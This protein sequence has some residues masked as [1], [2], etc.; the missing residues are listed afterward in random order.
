MQRQ[1][2]IPV[3]LGEAK[4]DPTPK[5]TDYINNPHDYFIKMETSHINFYVLGCAGNGGIPQHEV[6]AEMERIAK[7]SPNKPSFFILLG[8]N[9][10]DH[11]VD[12]A[13]SP[14]FKTYFYDVYQNKTFTATK[15]TP[16]FGILGNHCNDI[17][18][19]L[20]V[21]KAGNIDVR[22]PTAQV[23]HTFLQQ[24]VES[25]EKVKMFEGKYLVLDDLS[26]WNMP[27]RY[28]SITLEGNKEEGEKDLVLIFLDSSTYVKDYL[29]SLDPT[30]EN[31]NDNQA[32]WY[33]ATRDSNP[34]ATKITFLHHPVYSV[35]KRFEPSYSDMD[36]YLASSDI[37]K[38]TQNKFPNTASYNNLVAA[39]FDKQGL[40]NGIFMAA[41]THALSFVKTQ[42]FTQVISGGGGGKL[43]DR[44]NF[45]KL[46][47]FMPKY[48]FVCV[49]GDLADL[50]N[51]LK[52]DIRTTD[53]YHLQFMNKSDK[54]VRLD[55]H[56]P[57]EVTFLRELIL[58]AC[59]SY[60]EFMKTVPQTGFGSYFN[61]H[62]PNGFRR[63]DELSSYFNRNE[64]IF[65]DKAAIFL[66]DKM[67]RSGYE[68]ATSLISF[69]R[70][71]LKP[72]G[73][74]YEDFLK[75]PIV[76][77]PIAEKW[78]KQG[79]VAIPKSIPIPIPEQKGSQEHGRRRSLSSGSAGLFSPPVFVTP[80]SGVLS[81]KGPSRRN[82]LSSNSH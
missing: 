8:D 69:F 76:L 25:P 82:S 37:I 40:L 79:S 13:T 35:D 20:L 34:S 33:K 5:K 51:T 53:R 17:E 50:E 65:Y 74:T 6:A 7:S 11:G 52:F 42:S 44:Y 21:S 19:T 36:Q 1:Q 31:P 16:C 73:V 70:E 30:L 75:D 24:G 47:C 29:A 78:A 3:E 15:D 68:K 14:A 67:K 43:Q 81:G 39:A 49:S 4:A 57:A 59:D 26:K 9:F 41:H 27:R 58:N 45:N 71:N 10:Y 55:S 66:I 63:A 56:E 23:T 60:F 54:P 80:P 12:S 46:P 64:R 22:K 2:E 77:V 32:N 28:Y 61:D 18:R 72:F 62:G 38:L 48:G